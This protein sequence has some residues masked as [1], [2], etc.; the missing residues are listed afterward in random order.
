MVSEEDLVKECT[1]NYFE[2]QGFECKRTEIRGFGERQPDVIAWSKLTNT[3]YAVECKG[4]D[5]TALFQAIGQALPYKKMAHEVFVAVPHK[6]LEN[7]NFNEKFVQEQCDKTCINILFFDIKTG[8]LTHRIDSKTRNT[9]FDRE[10]IEKIKRK[11]Q[12]RCWVYDVFDEHP[13]YYREIVR[14]IVKNN[15]YA[16]TE[17]IL[18]EFSKIKGSNNFLRKYP[19]MK[20]TDGFGIKDKNAMEN[21]LLSAKTLGLITKAKDGWKLTP[22]GWLLY[23]Y[24]N[25]TLGDILNKEEEIIFK[26]LS[27]NSILS[28]EV[29]MIVKENPGITKKELSRELEKV[30]PKYGIE[31]DPSWFVDRLTLFLTNCGVLK[32]KR[33]R[34]GNTYYTTF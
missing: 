1:I 22:I 16:T 33:I 13:E 2:S 26:T 25:S 5:L 4:G 27:F 24:I 21:I 12:Q 6:I 14:I 11:F 18:K 17:D 8:R 29:Y 15:N 28:K 19:R 34:R 31:H 20:K 32:V 7:Q 10:L 3:V 30:L 9:E 23:A